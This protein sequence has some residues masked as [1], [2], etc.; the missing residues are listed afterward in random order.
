MAEIPGRTKVVYQITY[1]NGK[2]YVG[3]DRPD[4]PPLRSSRVKAQI[5]ADMTPEQRQDFTIRT[6]ILWQSTTAS[7][8]EVR[9]KEREF[10]HRPGLMTQSGATTSGPDCDPGG[11]VIYSQHRH[12][13]AQDEGASIVTPP[14]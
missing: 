13:S 8:I 10:I 11:P 9:E 6:Q 3:S 1:P 14:T 5:A 2:I 4:H 7:G 12:Q